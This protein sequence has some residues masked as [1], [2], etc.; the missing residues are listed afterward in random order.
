MLPPCLP[1]DHVPD[2]VPGVVLGS[3]AKHLEAATLLLPPDGGG[4]RVARRN[5]FD[6]VPVN[7]SPRLLMRLHRLAQGATFR[8]YKGLARLESAAG[9]DVALVVLDECPMSP[10]ARFLTAPPT[11]CARA[12]RPC[13]CSTR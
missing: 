11:S 13:C 1:S 4:R 2:E 8:A 3:A 6:V 9:H 12:C 10:L 7:L 5:M